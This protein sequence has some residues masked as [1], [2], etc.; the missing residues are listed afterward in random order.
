MT[1]TLATREAFEG[2]S[3]VGAPTRLHVKA[4]GRDVLLRDPPASAREEWEA[5]TQAHRGKPGAA[6]WRAKV[7][8]LLL[9]DEAGKPLFTED[10]LDFLGS[11]NASA[12][13]DVF[14]AGV[15]LLAITDEEIAVL[16]GN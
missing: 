9:C 12:M 14:T 8:Q 11:R 13:T 1:D 6:P 7:A 10:D 5:F 4:W 15:K 3:D 16:S 2:L